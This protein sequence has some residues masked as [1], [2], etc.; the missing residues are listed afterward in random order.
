V[1]GSLGYCGL[2]R[3]REPLAGDEIR[4][5]WEPRPDGAHLTV[6]APLTVAHAADAARGRAAPREFVE[7]E[8][9]RD[10]ADAT[11]IVASGESGEPA[12]LPDALA[13]L[14]KPAGDTGWSLW[15]DVER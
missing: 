3:K 4:A 6:I 2:D 12:G 7:I 5:C 1:A 13:P 15:G 11:A 10:L 9:A 14:I 8:G